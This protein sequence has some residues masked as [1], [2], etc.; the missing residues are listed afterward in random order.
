MKKKYTE[1]RILALKEAIDVNTNLSYL[2]FVY[3]K[4]MSI[5]YWDPNANKC[6][7]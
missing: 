6:I 5:K 4:I 7:K 1:M 2:S 3:E